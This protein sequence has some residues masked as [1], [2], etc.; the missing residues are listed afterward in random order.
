MKDLYI[1]GAGGLAREVHCL[2]NQINA[3]EETWNLVGFVD[4]N[5]AYRDPAFVT[6][7][8]ESDIPEGAHFVV[9]LGNIE[10]KDLLFHKCLKLGL[11]PAVLVH[12][13]T[14]IS[15]TTT[16]GWGS[17]ICKGTAMTADIVI[18]D[19]VYINHNVSIGHDVR[20]GSHSIVNP[21]AVIGGGVILE[22]HVLVG[23]GA[24]VIQYVTV[25]C[26][27]SVS[28]GSAVTR[29][30]PAGA[31]AIGVPASIMKRG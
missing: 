10:L 5:N 8:D 11:N 23:M 24:S 31:L 13:E 20:I 29:N 9:A 1:V 15:D 19:N 25:G 12:P 30:V 26:G 2:V 4:P 14:W 18:E 22:N 3:S 21:G 6:L 27:A 7:V 28:M 17:I 16:V